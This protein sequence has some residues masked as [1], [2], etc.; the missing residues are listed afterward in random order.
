MNEDG[1]ERQRGIDRS[2]GS[3][4]PEGGIRGTRRNLESDEVSIVFVKTA[5]GLIVPRPVELGDNDGINVEV[6]NGLREGDEIV[7][8]IF[9]SEIETMAENET[10]GNARSPFISTS[11]VR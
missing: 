3:T 8:R 1:S 10:E 7:Y 4:P 9:E 2:E 11:R 6:L 5:E